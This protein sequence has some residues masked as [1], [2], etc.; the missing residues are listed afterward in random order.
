MK[1][2]TGV[3]ATS[4]TATAMKI[5]NAMIQNSFA[6]PT[7]VMMLSRE[8]TMSSSTIWT[9]MP[10]KLLDIVRRTS[11]DSGSSMLL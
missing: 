11:L 3:A 5:A 6:I 1:F 2:A 7:A 10:A 9:M 4:I 8:N